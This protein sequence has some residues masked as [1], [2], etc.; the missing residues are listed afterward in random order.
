MGSKHFH[1]TSYAVL[2]MAHNSNMP[3]QLMQLFSSN[4]IQAALPFLMH[5]FS[6]MFSQ[7]TGL[8][9]HGGCN[10]NKILQ[11]KVIHY[12]LVHTAETSTYK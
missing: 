10:G 9:P 6:L 7:N 2:E 11:I 1:I 8:F 12:K 4:V 3:Q 5:N